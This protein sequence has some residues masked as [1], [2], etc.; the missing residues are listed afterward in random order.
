MI[1]SFRSGTRNMTIKATKTNP[2]NNAASNKSRSPTTSTNG[3]QLVD[4]KS[5]KGRSNIDIAIATTIWAND[6]C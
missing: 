1:S 5:D 3:V 2:V 6:G 4:K